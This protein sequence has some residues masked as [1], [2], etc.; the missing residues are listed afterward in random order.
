MTLSADGFLAICS[1]LFAQNFSFLVPFLPV[2]FFI[3][4][5]VFFSFSLLL[6]FRF[7]INQVLKRFEQEYRGASE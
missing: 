6:I 2:S 1:A 7:A 3:H 5:S 4:F